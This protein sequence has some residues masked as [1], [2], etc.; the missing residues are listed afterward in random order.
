MRNHFFKKGY[1]TGVILI[2]VTLAILLYP[3]PDQSFRVSGVWPSPGILYKGESGI[4]LTFNIELGDESVT[5]LLKELEKNDIR[6]A[7]FFLDPSW[8]DRQS[9]LVK[10]IHL[11]GFDI[12]I[13]DPHPSRFDSLTPNEVSTHLQ[14]LRSFFKENGLNVE[15]YRSKGSL[16]SPSLIKIMA[17]NNF[18]VVGHQMDWND[19]K[20][21]N[22]SEV[23]GAVVEL[24]VPNRLQD[25]KT[26]WEGWFASFESSKETKLVSLIELM[27]S[28]DSKIRLLE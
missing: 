6:K 18:I 14:E 7:T 1:E 11:A 26:E 23:K 27:A 10:D 21:K 3:A 4:A 2:V 12:G 19:I 25:I 13:Y 24:N 17:Q 28:S 16:S 15:Y 5:W 9:D 22:L 8:V 20:D